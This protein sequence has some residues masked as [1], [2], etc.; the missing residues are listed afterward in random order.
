MITILNL[1][2][3]MLPD[4]PKQSEGTN[5]YPMVWKV[6]LHLRKQTAKLLLAV[7]CITRDQLY[8]KLIEL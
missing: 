3:G 2:V 7:L 8:V 4:V 6:V 1:A 5:S